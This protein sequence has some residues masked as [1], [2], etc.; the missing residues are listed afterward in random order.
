MKKLGI[1]GVCAC[2]GLGAMAQ[3]AVLKEAERTMKKGA[4]YTEVVKAVTP[5][6]SDPSTK[7]N[8]M[9]YYLPGKAAFNQF[10]QLLTK[11]ALGQLDDAGKKTKADALLA[12]YEYMMKALPLDSVVDAKGKVKTKYSK[13]ILNSIGGH[14]SDFYGAGIDL[15]GAQ[16]YKKAYE[17]WNIYTSLPENPTFIAAKAIPQLPND[18]VIAEVM[19][20]QALAAWQ[21]NDMPLS[22]KSFMNAKNHGY[23][24][25]QLY[26]YAIAVAAQDHN[27]DAIVEL[28]QEAQTLYGDEDPN[29]MGYIINNYINKQQYKEAINMIDQAIA[30]DPS[31]AQ[32]HVIK[33][34]LLE[35]E[36]IQGDPKPEYEK[37]VELDDHN[38]QALYNLG[39][40]I[41]NEALNIYD[42]APNDNEGFNKV[43]NNDFKPKM[44][45]AIDL[46]ERAYSANED[47]TDPLRLLEN[48]YYMMNDDANMKATQ[49]RLGK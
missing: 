8:A 11:E 46:L 29:Y 37:A 17:A 7:D 13:D 4:D 28:A 27:D 9:T 48:A 23:Q 38:A 41:Y 12:G 47:Q 22:L 15:W 20:N 10:D 14:Y 33:G 19:Y 49:A 1:L 42:A 44:T 26:D 34:I 36:E 2:I 18:T 39:R 30:N 32:Y 24:K 31:N 6:M 25:K 45:Q 40:V 5:A 3:E 21:F 16:D 35:T 43:F